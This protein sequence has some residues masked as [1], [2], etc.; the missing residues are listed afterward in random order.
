MCHNIVYKPFLA[1]HFSFLA[2]L[3][4]LLSA[5]AA[6]NSKDMELGDPMQAA[7]GALQS[8]C[9]ANIVN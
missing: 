2:A 7:L 4:F 8:L 9:N 1:A 3:L 6:G 5:P